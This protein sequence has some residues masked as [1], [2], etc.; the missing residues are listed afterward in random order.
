MTAAT[1]GLGLMP[2]AFSLGASGT[3][4]ESPMA[5]I[6]CGGLITSTALNMLV[7]PTIYVWRV[8]RAHRAVIA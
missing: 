5:L 3:E 2:L 8:R 4:L 1:A 6:V 7:L